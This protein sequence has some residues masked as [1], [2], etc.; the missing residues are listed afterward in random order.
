M[1]ANFEFVIKTGMGELEHS[2]ERRLVQDIDARGGVAITI[3][4][5]DAAKGDL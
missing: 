5:P 3:R 4:W 1:L 2:K